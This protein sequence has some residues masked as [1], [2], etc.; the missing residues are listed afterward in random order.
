MH[1]CSQDAPLSDSLVFKKIA[2]RFG[3]RVK[4]VV[5]GGA[6]LSPH[7][8]EFLRVTM[9]TTVSLLVKTSVACIIW[10]FLVLFFV[11][12]LTSCPPHEGVPA[13]H[14]VHNGASV[15]ADPFCLSLFC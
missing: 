6:P 4:A 9:C 10:A 11:A 13:R 7:V 1:V 5:S 15:L 2:A 14:N 8:E 3:G 12:L